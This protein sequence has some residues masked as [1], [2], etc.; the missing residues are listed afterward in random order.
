[1]VS[2]QSSA[3][4]IKPC[5]KRR[6]GASGRSVTVV[7]GDLAFLHDMNSLYLVRSV[8]VPMIVVVLNNNG[9][10][11]FSFLPIAQFP[12]VFERYFGTPHNLTFEGVAK[13]FGVDYVSPP[14]KESF[15]EAYRAAT[16]TGRSIL[17]EVRTERK[18]NYDLLVRLLQ[19]IVSSLNRV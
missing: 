12:D 8:D 17:I 16:R 7:M 4:P 11:I 14:T 1:M 15:V 6:H 19:K 3:E 13:M 18:E 9:G 10:G 5:R 2:F